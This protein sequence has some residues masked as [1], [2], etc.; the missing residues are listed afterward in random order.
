MGCAYKITSPSGRSYIGVTT[1]PL[2]VRWEEHVI[3]SAK[4]KFSFSRAIYK[5]GASRFRLEVLVIADDLEYLKDLER[6]L[7]RL[8]RPQYNMTAGGDGCIGLALAAQKKKSK[9]LSF[10]MLQF[11]REPFLSKDRH[12]KF[13]EKQ[14]QL[15]KDPKHRAKMRN[16]NKLLWSDPIK[17]TSRCKHMSEG[18]RRSWQNPARK[19]SSATFTS[20]AMRRR[21]K[22]PEWRAKVMAS[23]IGKSNECWKDQVRKLEI[24][25]KRANTLARNKACL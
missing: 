24:L 15:W 22:D 7:I 17:K 8:Y 2:S 9:A 3:A 21:W 10:R 14:K 13:T 23:R 25:T 12:D 5:Y 4:R 16:V 20:E 19:A 11:W 1:R 6:Q 18:A